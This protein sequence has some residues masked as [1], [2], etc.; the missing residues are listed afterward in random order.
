MCLFEFNSGPIDPGALLSKGSTLSAADIGVCKPLVS[1]TP[2][3][4]YDFFVSGDVSGCDV[5]I[6]S[7]ANC[8]QGSGTILPVQANAGK[9]KMAPLLTG[10]KSY[11]L[12]CS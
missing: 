6:Y 8:P 12:T 4:S 1:S 3:M 10:V 7:S 9:C 5:V 11:K 2:V